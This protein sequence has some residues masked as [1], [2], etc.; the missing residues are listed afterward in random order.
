MSITKFNHGARFNFDGT[1]ENKF[2]SVADLMK[3]NGADTVY[4][5]KG[6][7]INKKGKYGDAPVAVIAGFNVN[8]PKHLLDTVKEMI[9][10]AEIVQQINEGKAGFRGDTYTTKEGKEYCTVRWEDL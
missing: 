6:F 1:E 5:L 8:L 10:D 7:Y 9:D 4:K 2:I 3:E